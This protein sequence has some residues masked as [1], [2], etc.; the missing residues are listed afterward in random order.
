MN[1]WIGD[2]TGLVKPQRAADS[3]RFL[4]EVFHDPLLGAKLDVDAMSFG[5]ETRFINDY[6]G[7]APR[8]NVSLN[9]YRKPLSGELS[10]GVLSLEALNVGAELLVDYGQ[11]FWCTA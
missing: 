10:V 9:V 8:P 5:N 6:M 1:T 2:F 4:L 7:I 11:G 3:S